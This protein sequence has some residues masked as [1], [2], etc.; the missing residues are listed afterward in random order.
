M[1]SSESIAIEICSANKY[2]NPKSYKLLENRDLYTSMIDRGKSPKDLINDLIPTHLKIS[3]SIFGYSLSL[4][5]KKPDGSKSSSTFT[6]Q[7]ITIGR[8]ESHCDLIF[9]DQDVSR[10]QCIIFF[11]K[12]KIMI[13]DTWSLNGTQ[14]KSKKTGEICNSVMGNRNLISYDISDTFDI[15]L[16]DR[17]VITVNPEMSIFTPSTE[18]CIVCMEKQRI[19]RLTC[20]HA[21]M[22]EE[23]STKI[24]NSTRKCPICREEATGGSHTEAVNTF[25]V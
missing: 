1:D 20:G 21:V 11:V 18:M 16:P 2:L 10:I 19:I 3:K 8:L 23:C 7:T 6:N 25:V 22:C 13:L 12:S 24:L 17:T 9:T 5:V 4:E 15:I 14:T